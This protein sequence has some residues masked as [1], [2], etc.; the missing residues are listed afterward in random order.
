M[1]QSAVP[2]PI[3]NK[4]ARPFRARTKTRRQAEWAGNIAGE[5]GELFESVPND[6]SFSSTKCLTKWF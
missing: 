1:S 2:I 4:L 6:L 5:I 3:S